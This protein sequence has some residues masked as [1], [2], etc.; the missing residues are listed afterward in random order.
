MVI[1]NEKNRLAFVLQLYARTHG[2]E[3][4]A[5]MKGA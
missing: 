2:P 4:I 1:G 5:Q 3:V